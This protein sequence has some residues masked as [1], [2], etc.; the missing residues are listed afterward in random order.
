[1]NTAREKG[2]GRREKGEG[3]REKGRGKCNNEHK[4]EKDWNIRRRT[5][6][7]DAF[8]GSG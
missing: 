8:A 1:M 5:T 6:G 4:N 7:Q 2:E 3:R